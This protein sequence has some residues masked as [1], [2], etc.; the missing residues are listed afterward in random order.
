VIAAMIR[1]SMKLSDEH[2]AA[3]GRVALAHT[4]LEMV[5]TFYLGQLISTDE[6]V[7][8][9][10]IPPMLGRKMD[11]FGRLFKLRASSEQFDEF[12]TLAAETKQASEARNQIM[13]AFV[14]GQVQ[15]ESGEFIPAVFN[16][17][18]EPNPMPVERV[19]QIAEH[20]HD[21]SARLLIFLL[22]CGWK[23]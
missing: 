10:V 4:R 15:T 16:T 7:A 19:Q 1:A 18:M 6:R 20:I 3:I 23:P 17:M 12:K 2:L 11:L 22:H 14:W 13:H 5:V 8:R 21:I 9:A